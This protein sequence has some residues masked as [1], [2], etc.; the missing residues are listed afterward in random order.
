MIGRKF[1]LLLHLQLDRYLAEHPECITDGVTM[2]QFSFQIPRPLQEN[3]VRKRHRVPVSYDDYRPF[4][5]G[6]GIYPIL[7]GQLKILMLS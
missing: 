2:S 7:L 3:Y 5:A 6:E 4:D 1:S